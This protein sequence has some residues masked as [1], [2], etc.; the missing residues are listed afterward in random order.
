MREK[1]RKKI[2]VIIFTKLFVTRRQI[3][4]SSK[5]K[6]NIRT[7]ATIR[8][9][10]GNTLHATQYPLAPNE[11]RICSKLSQNVSDQGAILIQHGRKPKKQEFELKKCRY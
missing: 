3:A 9:K 7:T 4:I 2:K 1:R 5:H 10:Q 11:D 8:A 6:L